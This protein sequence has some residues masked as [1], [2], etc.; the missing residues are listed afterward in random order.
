MILSDLKIYSVEDFEYWIGRN[1]ADVEDAVTIAHGEIDNP[2]FCVGDV[3]ELTDE[4]LDKLIYEDVGVMRTFGAQLLV[5]IALDRYDGMAYM[6][7]ST[8]F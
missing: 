1:V 8:E 6:L 3:R 7:A 2:D 5:E 4:E